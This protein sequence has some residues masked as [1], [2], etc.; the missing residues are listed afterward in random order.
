MCQ[1]FE[2]VCFSVQDLCNRHHSTGRTINNTAKKINRRVLLNDFTATAKRAF[3]LFILCA[4]YLKIDKTLF[5]RSDAICFCLGILKNRY[6]WIDFFFV[7]RIEKYARATFNTVFQ[8]L[9]SFSLPMNVFFPFKYTVSMCVRAF[10]VANAI[11][12]SM[13][14]IHLMRTH[15]HTRSDTCVCE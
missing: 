1:Q 11:M 13:A 4:I 14:L 9:N 12:Y 5:R 3:A 8:Q 10:D 7:S 15:R 6:K 2:S